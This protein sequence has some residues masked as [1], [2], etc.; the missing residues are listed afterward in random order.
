[1]NNSLKQCKNDCEE[2]QKSYDNLKKESYRPDKGY[3]QI[4]HK[5]PE[6][7]IFKRRVAENK[8]RTQKYIVHL[9]KENA[10]II[11]ELKQNLYYK[12]KSTEK[13]ETELIKLKNDLEKYEDDLQFYKKKTH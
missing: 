5:Y 12:N 3:T 2:L 6:I 11:E 9:K 13:Q 4:I 10:A 8:A 1:M 7:Q